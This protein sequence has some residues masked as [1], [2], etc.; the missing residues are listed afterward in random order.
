MAKT[1]IEKIASIEEE[2]QQLENKR[3]ELIQAQKKGG[4]QRQNQT[5]LQAHGAD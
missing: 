3:K 1:K 5:P 2:I 4:A